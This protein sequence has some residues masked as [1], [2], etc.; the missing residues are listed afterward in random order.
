MKF[1]E[2]FGIEKGDVVAL[3]GAGGKTSLLVGIGYELAEANWRV[4]A[5]AT[6]PVPAE[7]LDLMPRA[8]PVSAGPQAVSQ[9]LTESRFVFLYDRIHRGKVYGPNPVFIQ[10]LLDIVD[11]DVILVEADRADN[12]PFKAP[13]DDEPVIPLG[14][15]LVIPVASFKA[16]GQPLDD[17]HVYNPQSMVEQCGFTK[18]ALVRPSWI[19]QVVRDENMGMRGIPPGV[20]TVAFFNQTPMT[21]YARKRAR[22]AARIALRHSTLQA[23]ALGEVRGHEPVREVQRTVGAVVL[24]AGLSSRMGQHKLLL[25]W[26]PDQTL[27]EHIVEQLVK[28]RVDPIVVVTG[29]NAKEVRAVLNKWDVKFVQN[30]AYKTADMLSSLKQG[31]EAMPDNVSAALMVLGDQPSIQPKTIQK[32]LNA[33]A[34]DQQHE[35]VIPSY[36]MRRGHPV[37]IGRRYWRD[38]L[39]L[40]NSGNPRQVFNMYP[41]AIRYVEM[42]SDNILRDVDTPQDYDNE[43]DRADLR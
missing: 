7:Q 21:S 43:R 16:V 42:D 11:S 13:H 25:P 23:V 14:T 33:Y 19:A 40:P 38:F 2:A 32:I 28:A 22:A 31:L 41:D 26:K 6:V 8:L 12:L 36:R 37:L 24:A 29:H 27:I 17:L 10:Q 4:L 20:R 1:R 39:N 18:G 5:T 30:R 15:S 35:L 34:E 9:A 3:I